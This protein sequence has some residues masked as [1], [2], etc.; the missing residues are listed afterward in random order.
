MARNL[1]NVPTVGQVNSTGTA[2][3]DKRLRRETWIDGDGVRWAAVY[4][5]DPKQ[6]CWLLVSRFEAES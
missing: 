3:T 4:R 6:Q 1:S 2:T 5:F